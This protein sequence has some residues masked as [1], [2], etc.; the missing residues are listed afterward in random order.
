M[1]LFLIWPLKKS[2]PSTQLKTWEMMPSPLLNKN[3]FKKFSFY[4]FSLH[5]FQNIDSPFFM[6]VNLPCIDHLQIWVLSWYKI[7]CLI[8]LKLVI[9]FWILN[10]NGGCVLLIPLAYRGTL[11]AWNL[12]I[13][14][15]NAFSTFVG[16]MLEGKLKGFQ[17]KVK[18]LNIYRLYK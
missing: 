14:E 15:M 13:A 3:H 6:L 8:L 1:Y 9:I 16:I 11:V 5:V 12:S 4:L 2:F 7:L 18:I 10:H 17:S